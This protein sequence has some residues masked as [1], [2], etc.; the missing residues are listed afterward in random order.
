MQLQPHSRAGLARLL[1]ESHRRLQDEFAELFRNTRMMAPERT[2]QAWARL[3][4][5]L[6][7]HLRLEEQSLL[8]M[9]EL[10]SSAEAVGLRAEHHQLLRELG[11]LGVDLDLHSFE[12]KRAEG[13]LALL[14]AHVAREQRTLY[15]WAE[16]GLSKRAKAFFLDMLRTIRTRRGSF[17]GVP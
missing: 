14:D 17:T 7:D 8:P 11:W 15:L 16:T 4:R 1:T 2:R 13:F 10:H 3:D 9:F 5:E 6:R 12:E